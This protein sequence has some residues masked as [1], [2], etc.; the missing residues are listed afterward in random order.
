MNH[1]LIALAVSALLSGCAST[2]MAEIDEGVKKADESASHAIESQRAAKPVAEK[3]P[4]TAV[5][6]IEKTWIPVMK[7]SEAD[8]RAAP[9]L[10][11]NV[12]VNRPIGNIHEAASYIT[13][14][15]GVPV[16]VATAQQPLQNAMPQPGAAPGVM[17]GV[18]PPGMPGVPGQG[19]VQAAPPQMVSYNGRLAGLLDILAAKFGLYWETQGEGVRFFKTKPRTFRLA[20]L[21]GDS[22]MTSSVGT[23]SSG[24]GSSNGASTTSS[25]EQRS[26][27]KFAD[28]SIWKGVEDSI[29][30]MLSPDGRAVVTPATGTVTV[31][32]TPPTLERVAKFIEDQNIALTRQVVLN[33]RVLAVDL[34]DTNSYGINWNVIYKNLGRG[35]GMAL[36]STSG[37]PAGA[38]N[39]SFNIINT[40]SAW[41]G[42]QLMLEALSKQ[43]KVSQVTSAS[44]VTINNQP[45]PIQVGRQKSYLASSTTTLGTGGA[46]NTTTLTPGTV[47]TGFSMSVLPHILD[48]GRLMLQY[49]GDISALVDIV[50]VSS[51]GSSIQTPEIDTR[52]FLQRVMMSNGETLVLTGFEQFGLSGSKQGVGSADNMALG[53]GLKTSNNRSVLVVLIQ[54][55]MIGG[56]F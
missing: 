41:D 21:P 52:N 10:N 4:E 29:K 39:L 22:S 5:R 9:V 55:V 56:N 28:L 49:S 43:G 8:F 35:V 54:P 16:F 50:T 24:G 19:N 2:M 20:A 27:I 32:D 13:S 40:N 36:G 14:L 51:G 25:S 6:R 12:T 26:G 37:L 46:G 18:M 34:T 48:S 15:T 47:T 44:L 7:V 38:A 30:A 17:P 23:Q 1:K 42:T 53:G 33:V 3:A 45:A 11:R 31:D